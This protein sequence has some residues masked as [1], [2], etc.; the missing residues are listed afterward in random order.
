MGIP[1]QRDDGESTSQEA[2]HQSRTDRRLVHAG[3]TLLSYAHETE[4][5]QTG[6]NAVSPAREQLWW[7]GGGESYPHA[8]MT[9]VSR[10][11]RDT[12]IQVLILALRKRRARRV[13]RECTV[14]SLPYFPS[15]LTM[16][17]FVCYPTIQ[18]LPSSLPRRREKK[19]VRRLY[20]R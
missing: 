4:G 10:P 18:H 2:N 20:E 5:R 15:L 6:R 14:L 19:G 12:L 7:G 17:N 3:V 13:S 9:R 8:A 1:S 11:A 16:L